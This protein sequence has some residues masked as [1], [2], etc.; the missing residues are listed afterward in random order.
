MIN[1][2][3]T[4]TSSIGTPVRFIKLARNH[5]SEA[6]AEVINLSLAQGVVPDIIKISKVIPVYK[7]GESF[8]P[9]NYRPISIL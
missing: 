9:V 3:N 6:L 5:I 4:N 8:D 2:L 1:N 7:G